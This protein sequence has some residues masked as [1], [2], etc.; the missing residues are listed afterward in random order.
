MKSFKKFALV[1]AVALLLFGSG[2]NMVDTPT[3][4]NENFGALILVE[5]FCVEMAEDRTS[6][7]FSSAVVCDQFKDDILNW[8]SSKGISLDCVDAIFMI[9]AKIKCVSFQGSHSWD[10][11]SSTSI[12]RTDISDGPKTLLTSQTLTVPNECDAPYYYRPKL[13]LYGVLLVNRAL[14]DLVN[15]GDPAMV[16]EMKATDVDPEPS[17]NDHLTFTWQAC[18][19][20]TAIVDKT[21]PCDGDEDDDD[22]DH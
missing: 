6:G 15:G 2:C 11:T 10:I 7:N 20:V 14:N 18:V 4:P 1:P 3:Q 8:F 19:T 12:K 13:G 5:T 22:D 21:L 16:V 9:A 17:V